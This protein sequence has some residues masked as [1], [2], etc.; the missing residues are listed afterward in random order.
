M[1]AAPLLRAWLQRLRQAGV[2]F[3][4]RH[5]WLGW[6]DDRAG[7]PLVFATAAGTRPVHADIVVLALGGASWPRLG[8][9]AAWVRV[10]QGRGVA[11]APL[12]ASNCGFDVRWSEHFRRK[13][14]GQPVKT[15]A[16]TYVDGDGVPL[17]RVG[18]FTV[19]ESGVEG[20]LVYT[21]SAVLR[22]RIEA[23]GATTISV[24]LLPDWT[25]QRVA[26]EVGR[27]RGSNSW[28]RHLHRRLGLRGVK[29]ALLYELARDAFASTTQLAAAIK[30]LPLRLNAP[31]P[32]DEA[33][34]SAGGVI[35]AELDEH[36]MIRRL[37]GVFCAGEMLDWEAPTGGYLLNACFA[38][39]RVAG[40]GAL[41][42]LEQKSRP[43]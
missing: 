30:A 41:A 22:D 13:F 4:V 11:V 20:S 29:T 28:S 3:H 17:R 1:K 6:Q 25:L 23:A 16:V 21:L 19:T 31:R 40:R 33:I 34:S 26:D 27:P 14:A 39:G 2:G 15:A 32:I 38:S 18:E 5:R 24:D 42:W 9:D 7:A 37:P 36:L 8:S 43:G 12:R 35:F 10:L